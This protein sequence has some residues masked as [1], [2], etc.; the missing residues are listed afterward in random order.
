VG[1]NNRGDNPLDR[2][3]SLEREGFGSQEDLGT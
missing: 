1:D 3:K 2:L